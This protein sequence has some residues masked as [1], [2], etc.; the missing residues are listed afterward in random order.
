MVD[1]KKTSVF[2]CISD[3]PL[4]SGQTF[5]FS[6]PNVPFVFNS[7]S[8]LPSQNVTELNSDVS[9]LKQ[10][11]TTVQS[12][13]T[14]PM[15]PATDSSAEDNEEC[16][17]LAE[18]KSLIESEKEIE[19]VKTV[20]TTKPDVESSPVIV[21]ETQNESA[22]IT[23]DVGSAEVKSDLVQD[24]CHSVESSDK[25]VESKPENGDE[26]K[27]KHKSQTDCNNTENNSVVS[28]EI[29]AKS[30]ADC[31]V[32]VKK[33]RDRK[34][35]TSVSRSS[36]AKSDRNIF[37]DLTEYNPF[38]DPHVLQAADGLELLSALAVA[39]KS[40][41]TP[42]ASDETAGDPKKSSLDACKTELKDDVYT[43]TDEHTTSV[44]KSEEKDGVNISGQEKSVV[45]PEKNVGPGVLSEKIK[46]RV[47]CGHAFKPRKKESATPT[48]PSPKRMMTF[49]G[50]MIPEGEYAICVLMSVLKYRFMSIS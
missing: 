29:I 1:D 46:S 3:I 36:K 27:T 45:I 48:S 31:T 21:H 30:K 32:S 34:K 35:E 25:S 15:L 42:N 16:T 12:R 37:T 49:C 26:L 17:T 40:S 7:N 5:S 8:L 23:C 24:K 2:N 44:C 50:I 20:A 11:Q 28:T 43:F 22:G 38:T 14:S 33:I 18:V 47:R 10:E 39:E 41:L 9:L 13:G 6:T 19:S 4:A